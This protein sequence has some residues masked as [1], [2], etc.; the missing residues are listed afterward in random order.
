[1]HFGRIGSGARRLMVA[2]LFLLTTFVVSTSTTPPAAA[3]A[4]TVLVSVGLDGLG[5]DQGAGNEVPGLGVSDDGN[6]VVFGSYSSNLVAGDTN[7][8]EDVFVRDIAA[9]STTLVSVDENGQPATLTSFQ[10]VISGNGRYVGFSSFDALVADDHNDAVDVYVRDLSTGTVAR[11]SLTADGS[12][13]T[14]SADARVSSISGDGRFVLMTATADNLVV[15]LLGIHGYHG[16]FVRDRDSDVDGIFDEPGAATT[17]RLDVDGSGAPSDQGT[18][19]NR[20]TFARAISANGR[21]VTFGTYATN[22][23][24]NHSLSCSFTEPDPQQPSGPPVVVPTG[25][26]NVYVRDRDPDMNGVFDEATATTTLASATAAGVAAD[27]DSGAGGVSDAGDVAMWSRASNLGA[28]GPGTPDVVVRDRTG[29]VSVVGRSISNL[30]V[31]GADGRFVVFDSFD[32]NGV[33]ADGVGVDVF[34]ADRSGGATE[35]ISIGPDG[36]PFESSA[37]PAISADASHVAFIAIG[38]EPVGS[39]RAFNVY[40]REV[41]PPAAPDALGPTIVVTSPTARAYSLGESATVAYTCTDPSGVATCTGPVVDGAPLDTSVAGTTS[42]TVSA[43]DTLGNAATTTVDFDVLAGNV[44]TT[45]APGDVVTT[46]PGGVG[47]SPDV[48][49]Q[50]AIQVPQGVSGPVSV[51]PAPLGPSPTGFVLVGSDLVL[52]GPPASATQPYRVTFTLDASELGGTAVGDLA[53]FRNGVAVADCLT[54]DRADPDPC[55]VSR[56]SAADGSGDAAIAV[57]TSA[58]STWVLGRRALAVSGVAPAIIAQGTSRPAV[59]TA[60]GLRAGATATVSGAGVSASSS[61][62]SSTSLRVDLT[63]APGAAPGARNVTVTNADG[64][65]SICVACL[66]VTARPTIAL[67]APTTQLRGASHRLVTVIGASFAPGAVSVVSGAGVTIH[68]TTVLTTNLLV[69]DL[70]VAPTAAPGARDLTITNPDGGSRTCTGCVV[71]VE[72]PTIAS[73]DPGVRGQGAAAVTVTVRGQQFRPGA[74]VTFSGTGLAVGPTT[75]VDP[76]TI[77]VPV[78]VGANAPVGARTVTV[79]NT[80][81]SATAATGAFVVA[82]RPS[83]RSV[84]PGTQR[85]GTTATVVVSGTSFQPGATVRLSGA[86][87]QAIVLSATA[88][89]LTLSVTVGRTASTTARNVTVINPDGGTA[90]VGNAY[91][92]NP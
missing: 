79:I 47:A 17:T 37:N 64:E 6:L 69:L 34:R 82:P 59:V 65:S 22:L 1:M 68:G 14:G 52:S 53:V 66:T 76:T 67:V 25:C 73:V 50:T 86:D 38:Q 71:V 29:A 55:V 2:P 31:I 12:E 41:G 75:V 72:R 18:D 24:P 26:L 7:A 33:A 54:P 43:T 28:S 88:T 35:L 78:A 15:P 84:T 36:T 5:A 51:T 58:F 11:V 23:V 46:D 8:V 56:T 60:V 74:V 90:T 49:V 57:N 4:G 30:P 39:T 80:D 87:V 27:G 40:R 77:T 3:A 89:R 32:A 63:V 19:R 48:P 61:V 13:L 42:F 62:L 81:G 92:I 91:R 10:P 83:V 20:A 45:V 16:V 21:F 9:G 70:S 44:T 85:R